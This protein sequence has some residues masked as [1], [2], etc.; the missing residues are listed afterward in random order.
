LWAALLIGCGGDAEPRAAESEPVQAAVDEPPA[1]QPV[2]APEQAGSRVL[3]KGERNRLEQQFAREAR[4]A[5]NIDSAKAE[6]ER[7]LQ[8]VNEE[9]AEE[10]AAAAVQ[11][12]P[13]GGPL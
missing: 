7:L 8:L 1:E 9:L 12:N 10:R 13:S 4:A 2:A 3:T 5:I 11:P 6:G